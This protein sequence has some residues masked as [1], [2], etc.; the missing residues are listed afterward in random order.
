VS[1]AAKAVVPVLIVT[2]FPPTVTSDGEKR[3]SV[4][5][6]DGRIMQLT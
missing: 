4:S 3:M 2:D 5:Y 6:S 1:M